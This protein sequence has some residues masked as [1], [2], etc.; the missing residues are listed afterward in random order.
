MDSGTSSRVPGRVP[1]SCDAFGVG[2]SSWTIGTWEEGAAGGGMTGGG[3]GADTGTK[4]FVISSYVSRK[5]N[6]IRS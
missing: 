4:R 5:N 6:K 2:G 3:A 1:S